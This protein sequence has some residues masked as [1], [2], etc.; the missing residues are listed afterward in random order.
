MVVKRRHDVD[1]EEDEAEGDAQPLTDYNPAEEMNLYVEGGFYG[2][3]FIVGSRVV[4]YEFLDKPV[5]P[6]VLLAKVATS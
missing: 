2:H 1:R 6:D 5:K 4:R 3:P